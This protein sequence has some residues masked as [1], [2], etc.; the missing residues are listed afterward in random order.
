MG[1]IRTE[2]F[3]VDFKKERVFDTSPFDNTC[4]GKPANNLV[5]TFLLLSREMFHICFS[6]YVNINF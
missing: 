1:Y 2:I 4:E 3:G 6:I 5:E